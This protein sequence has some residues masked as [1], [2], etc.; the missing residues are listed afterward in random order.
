MTTMM[1]RWLPLISIVALL[2]VGWAKG[3]QGYPFT[4][5]TFTLSPETR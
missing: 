4:H 3:K 1:R 5:L 2:R